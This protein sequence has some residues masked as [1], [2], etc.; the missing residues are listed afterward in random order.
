MTLSNLLHNPI[1]AGAYVYGRRPS[2]PRRRQPGR[3]STG[4]TVAGPEQWEVLLKDRLP[5]YIGWEQYEHNLRQLA[6]NTAQG[7]GV[8]RGG[9]RCYRGG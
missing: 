8:A 7:G 5:A 6:A 9:P 3:P 4:R 2:D 1:Y